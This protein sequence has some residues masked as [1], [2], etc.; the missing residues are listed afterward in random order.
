[1]ISP[2]TSA[3][4]FA[5]GEELVGQIPFTSEA[6]ALRYVDL[7]RVLGDPRAF[8]LVE[9]REQRNLLDLLGVQLRSPVTAAASAQP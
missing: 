6:L 3:V 2:S 1:M 4:P 8:A 9:A 5:D 7:V